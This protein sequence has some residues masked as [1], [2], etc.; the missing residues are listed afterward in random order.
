MA[1]LTITVDDETLKRARIRAI[2][3]GQSVNAFLS[4]QLWDFANED[5]EMSRQE[6]VMNELFRLADS[7]GGGRSDGAGWRREGLYDQ[8]RTQ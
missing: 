4:A 1:N 2:E 8:R 6:Q 5:E 7:S 3:R